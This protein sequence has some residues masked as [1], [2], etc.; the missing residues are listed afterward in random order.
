MLLVNLCTNRFFNLQIAWADG[1]LTISVAGDD[2]QAEYCQLSSCEGKFPCLAIPKLFLDAICS[3][4]IAIAGIPYYFCMFIVVP[5]TNCIPVL[6]SLSSLQLQF[7]FTCG[8]WPCT[9]NMTPFDILL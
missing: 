4:T 7:D 3:S 8:I 2:A 1:A 6:L 5:M 9:R